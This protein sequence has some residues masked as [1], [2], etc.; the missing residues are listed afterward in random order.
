MPSSTPLPT[1]RGV[2]DAAQQ[3]S[4]AQRIEPTASAVLRGAARGLLAD[5]GGFQAAELWLLDKATTHLRLVARWADDASPLAEAP[6]ERRRPLESAPAEVAALGGGAVAL[7][8]REEAIAW[9]LAA[10]AAAALCVPVSSGDAVS[11]VVWLMADHASDLSDEAVELAEIVATRLALE[12]ERE[13]AREPASEATANESQ[14]AP[15]PAQPAGRRA[16]DPPTE[17]QISPVDAAA[18]RSP[19]VAGLSLAGCWPLAGDRMLALAAAA[20]ESPGSTAASLRGAIDWLRLEAPPM[21]PLAA[22]AGELLTELNRRMID[23]PLAGEGLAIAAAIVDPP[24]DAE[25]GLGGAGTFAVAGPT[26]GLSIRATTA[27]PHAG[28]LIPVGWN[29]PEASY[30][31]RPFELAVRQRL[32]LVAGD[33]RLTSPLAERRL[34]DAYTRLTADAHRAMTPAACLTRLTTAGIDEAWSAAAI[35]RV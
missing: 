20:I 8:S 4:L 28:D 12:V 1:R 23:S 24:E 21:A 7:E 10:P 2:A 15:L 22:D 9:E 30:A 11:G 19:D 33:P 31:P 25:A 27:E 34:A 16:T 3:P 26:V 32:L 13:A 5:R 14:R 17:A 6:P 18:W 29:E 35:R